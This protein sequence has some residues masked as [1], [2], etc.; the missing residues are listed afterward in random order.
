MTD[1]QLQ[2]SYDKMHLSAVYA[3]KN[4][5]GTGARLTSTHI[6]TA[7]ALLFLSEGLPPDHVCA[8]EDFAATDES[9]DEQ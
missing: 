3:K 7:D 8:T 2:Q 6:A 4:P 5:I 9:P 1:A